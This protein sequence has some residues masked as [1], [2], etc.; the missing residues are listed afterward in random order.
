M[1]YRKIVDPPAVLVV[2]NSDRPYPSTI[3]GTLNKAV[4]LYQ[5]KTGFDSCDNQNYIQPVCG[6]HSF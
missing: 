5:I 1:W 2:I 3:V 4:L 6:E